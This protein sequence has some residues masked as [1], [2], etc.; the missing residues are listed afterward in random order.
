[1]TRRIQVLAC[2]CACA[3][4]VSGV[5]ASAADDP[6]SAAAILERVR[7]GWQGE[8]FHATVELEVTLSGAM[9]RHMLEVWTLGEDHALLRVIEPA[10]DAGSGYLQV[11]D[12]LWYYSPSVGVSIAL[13]T[14]GLTDALFGA[15]PSIGDL[16]QGTL[17][18]DYDAQAEEIVDPD[19]GQLGYLLTLVPRADAPVVYGKLEVSVT[20]EFVLTEIVYYDQRGGVIRTATFGETILLGGTAFPT[21]IVVVDESGDRTVQRI[22]DPEFDVEIDAAFFTLE[23]LEAGE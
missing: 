12:E 5:L 16:S 8:S 17:S 4:A 7:S 19:G 21:E 9:K 13:P 1:M 6:F 14:M 10:A 23:R 11:G 15:G 22:L 20:V 18:S 3:L 2:G